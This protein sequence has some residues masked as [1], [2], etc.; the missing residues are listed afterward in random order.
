MGRGGALASTIRCW[1]SGRATSSST[2]T[3]SPGSPSGSSPDRRA[4]RAPGRGA[5]L[6]IVAMFLLAAL[7][8]ARVRPARPAARLRRPRASCGATHLAH[9]RDRQRDVPLGAV[10]PAVLAARRACAAI[11]MDGRRQAAQHACSPDEGRL[12][13]TSSAAGPLTHLRQ[14]V[15]RVA[16]RGR[17]GGR[18]R[19]R[20]ARRDFRRLGVVPSR[21][22][23]CGT[24]STRPAPRSPGRRSRAPTSSTRT[25]GGPAVRPP[26]A[27]MR[28]AG[29]CIRCTACPEEI[30]ARVGRPGAPVPPGVSRAPDRVARARH[31]ADRGAAHPA[32]P[33]RRPVAGDRRLP[34]PAR[35]PARLACT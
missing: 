17:R 2:T 4:Q 20:G 1:A 27:R 9:D 21:R 6:G 15:P 12:R 19:E 25:T 10:L 35:V 7:P 33:R 30:A 22:R 34:C 18:L 13:L 29:R 16:A 8:R 3:S 24:S 23:R 26:Q 14:L 5:E 32:R 11:W 31:P 28:G